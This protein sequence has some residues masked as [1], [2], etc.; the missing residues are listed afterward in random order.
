MQIA[1]LNNMGSTAEEGAVFLSG[2]AQFEAALKH[3]HDGLNA[4][5]EGRPG[6]FMRVDRGYELAKLALSTL[7]EFEVEYFAQGDDE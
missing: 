4:Q 5:H 3:I 6:G 7:R 1:V 2:I